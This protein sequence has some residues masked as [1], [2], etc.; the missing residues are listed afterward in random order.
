MRYRSADPDKGHPFETSAHLID[1]YCRRRSAEGEDPLAGECLAYFGRMLVEILDCI[2]AGRN[3]PTDEPKEGGSA[4][5]VER[6]SGAC[7]DVFLETNVFTSAVL[8]NEIQV[9]RL[10]RDVRA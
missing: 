8:F 10:R 6:A 7:T 2:N 9:T 5:S 4:G 1:I 3:D